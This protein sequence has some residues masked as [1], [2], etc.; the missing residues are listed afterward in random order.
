M[1]TGHELNNL[2]GVLNYTSEGDP[3][4][5]SLMKVDRDLKGI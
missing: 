3:I 1:L 2:L 5:G 4:I